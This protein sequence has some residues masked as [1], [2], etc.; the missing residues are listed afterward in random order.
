V[1]DIA[2]RYSQSLVD[3]VRVWIRA[4]V[5]EA[6]EQDFIVKS[7]ARKLVMPTTRETCKR[8]LT[9]DEYRAMLG[10]LNPRDRLIFRLFVLCALRPGELFA[11]RWRNFDG[12]TLSIEE[13]V[14]RGKLGKPKTRGSVAH[15][16]VP[17]SLRDEL[18]TW[19]QQSGT[20]APDEFIFPSEAGTP[21]DA[22]NYLQR[23]ALKPAATKVG[24][25]GITFQALRRTFATH[26]HGVGT[27]KDQQAQMRHTHASTT[28]NV[29][30]QAVA[31]SRMQSI[32][33]FEQKMSGVLNT[34]EHG[35][36]RKRST[37][38]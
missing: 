37:S 13:A 5:E 11:L 4:V 28:M 23:D 3:K 34:F 18:A 27:V 24:I 17:P 9:I 12:S 36:K 14:Y 21:L 25:E 7:P 2:K 33:Q 16:V 32:E 26:F 38:A 35:R 8:F 29:Y 6:V 1:N 31:E 15:V 20:P 30:T 22:H 10:V 19:F